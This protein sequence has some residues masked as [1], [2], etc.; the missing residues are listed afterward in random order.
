LYAS[1][2]NFTSTFSHLLFAEELAELAV[3]VE[4]DTDGDGEGEVDGT[5]TNR[6]WL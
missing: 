2:K 4:L 5:K 1:I 3:V 6:P